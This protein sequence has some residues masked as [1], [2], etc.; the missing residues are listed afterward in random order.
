MALGDQYPEIRIEVDQ[1]LP[2]ET[3]VIGEKVDNA[4]VSTEIT[5]FDR[6]GDTYIL[7]GILSFSGTVASAA[8]DGDPEQAL[9]VPVDY[10]LPFALRIPTSGQP[11]YLDVKTRMRDWQ[12]G[13]LPPNYLQ[14]QAELTVT[15]LDARNGYSFYCGDQ[16][17]WVLPQE[18]EPESAEVRQIEQQEEDAAE[19]STANSRWESPD[20]GYNE[21][22]WMMERSDE[23][24]AQDT[25]VFE[26]GSAWKQQIDSGL[27]SSVQSGIGED[28][29]AGEETREEVFEF[30]ALA[31]EAAAQGDHPEKAESLDSI[32]KTT[33]AAVWSIFD[34]PPVA[35]APLQM[36]E[37]LAKSVAA[38]DPVL[39]K[40]RGQT[41]TP[42][43]V[44]RAETNS[45]TAETNSVT[46]ETEGAEETANAADEAESIATENQEPQ[47]LVTA[48]SDTEI[49]MEA[50]ADAAGSEQPVQA[51]AAIPDLQAESAMQEEPMIAVQESAKGGPKVS[52]G[53]AKE[54]LSSI[55]LSGLLSGSVTKSD[56]TEQMKDPSSGQAA[57]AT[58][59][60][61]NATMI[62]DS[63]LIH[64]IAGESADIP[65]TMAE[66]GIQSE[67]AQA[68]N[69][70]EDAEYVNGD[71]NSSIWG[72]WLKIDSEQ[73]YT[74]KFRIIQESESLEQV[75]KRFELPIENLMRANGLTNEQVDPGQV[76]LIPGKR[77]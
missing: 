46:A 35:P 58:A 2:L 73:G 77:R 66:S 25:L 72:N 14:V 13:V 17:D 24:D 40:A 6:V 9:F 71:Q 4:T 3:A 50:I 70:A 29:R 11:D 27:Q 12:I 49:E 32:A 5:H 38:D 45:V 43:S 62:S 23:P 7:E 10:Q 31:D 65:K 60:N 18:M 19:T 34:V 1:R 44:P 21:Q 52:F 69:E 67:S 64:G 8:R 54:E 20:S 61:P 53:S 76:L 55:K 74:L 33:P 26:P 16:E 57:R 63:S 51:E 30:E 59:A 75:A 15:G 28:V 37:S 36:E 68:N 48:V 42:Y 39:G 56:R 47:S 41:V 22:D